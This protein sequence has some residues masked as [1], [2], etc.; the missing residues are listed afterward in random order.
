MTY[1]EKLEQSEELGIQVITLPANEFEYQEVPV[2]VKDQERTKVAFIII[3]GIVQSHTVG[4]SI[5]L[6]HSD[7][8]KA[9]EAVIYEIKHMVLSDLAKYRR[10][11]KY[12]ADPTCNGYK[13][14]RESLA[15]LYPN[16][17]EGEIVTLIFFAPAE[18]DS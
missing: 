18:T 12:Y 10:L 14:I 7:Q 4:D 13:S 9:Q 17:I 3:Q 2:D 16:L 11:V 1:E 15:K 6:V 5:L 8:E